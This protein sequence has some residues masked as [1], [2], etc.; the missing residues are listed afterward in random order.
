MIK[1]FIFDIDGT[2]LDSNDFHAQAWVE[3]FNCYGKRISFKRIRRCMGE[4]SDQLLPEF[5][6]KKEIK[7]I[8]E[9]LSELSGKIFKYK[10]FAKVRP[11][12]KVRALFKKIRQSG[13][14]IALASSADAGEVKKYEKIARIQN[15]VEHSTSADDAE[16]SKP[17]P[18]IFHAALRLLGHPKHDSVLVIGDSPFDAMAAG[19]AKIPA[20]GVLCGGFSKR[21]LKAYGCRA[22]YDDP[23]DLLNN[24]K[25]ILTD[26]S[27][28]NLNRI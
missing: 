3:A 15:L 7:E 26:F 9:D 6:N 17:S 21:V 27:F 24:L 8:G 19:K 16:K 28:A 10:Y 23:A 11:F 4:G 14:R 1:N 5:L 12:P 2:L 18:D 25:S 20:I 22:V 13:A